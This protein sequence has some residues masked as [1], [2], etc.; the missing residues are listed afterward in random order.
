MLQDLENSKN[1]CNFAIVLE[2]NP[3]LEANLLLTRQTEIWYISTEGQRVIVS[4]YMN[5]KQMSYIAWSIISLCFCWVYQS[6]VC[7]K[8]EYYSA[9]FCR[10][11]QIITLNNNHYE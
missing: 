11:T 10:R 7:N 1:C 9:L 8:V 4:A 6:L 3:K 2:R 5:L